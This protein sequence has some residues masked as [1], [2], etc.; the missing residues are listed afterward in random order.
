[1]NLSKL[2]EP[3]VFAVNIEDEPMIKNDEL[4]SAVAEGDYAKCL[5][6]LNTE[7]YQ[8]LTLRNYVFHPFLDAA[9][10]GHDKILELFLKQGIDVNLKN[11]NGLDAIHFAA[12]QGHEK[13]CNLL[14]DREDID[15]IQDEKFC[16][17]PIH[18]AVE[19]KLLNVVLRLLKKGVD[20]NIKNKIQKT[21]VHIAAM[22]GYEDILN[23]LLNN[24]GRFD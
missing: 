23:R 12:Q 16:N 24:P 13:C 20:P 11:I 1:M 15:L 18:L 8:N 5:Q 22:R 9:R 2:N 10:K 14:L 7:E 19:G 4:T 17:H 21:P 6:L 3:F